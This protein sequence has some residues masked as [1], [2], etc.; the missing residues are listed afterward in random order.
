MSNIVSSRTIFV[1]NLSAKTKDKDLNNYFSKF[2]EV[3]NIDINPQKGTAFI[4]FMES[5]SAQ[6]AVD[7]MDGR[8]YEG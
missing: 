7:E 6:H 2:G 4:K 3:K 1:G 8:N 5:D